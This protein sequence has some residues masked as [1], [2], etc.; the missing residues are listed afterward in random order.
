MLTVR[1]FDL[2]VCSDQ[3]GIEGG[4]HMRKTLN[5]WVARTKRGMEA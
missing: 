4:P 1:G 5:L 3:A 2:H